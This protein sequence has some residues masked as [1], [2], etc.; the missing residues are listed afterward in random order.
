[1]SRETTALVVNEHKGPFSLQQVR[2]GQLGPNEV[3]VEIAASG[4]CHN[5]LACAKGLIPTKVPAIFGHEGRLPL[6]IDDRSVR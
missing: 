2:I 3:L 1:M 4:I 6:L 5:D